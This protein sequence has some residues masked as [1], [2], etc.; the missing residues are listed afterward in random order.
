MFDYFIRMFVHIFV[1]S[2]ENK[3]LFKP[4]GLVVEGRRK[5]RGVKIKR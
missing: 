1:F 2:L 4:Y 5:E 3:V